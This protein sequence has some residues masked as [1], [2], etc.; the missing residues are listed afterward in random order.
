MKEKRNFLI[1]LR[2]SSKERQ[3]LDEIVEDMGESQSMCVRQLIREYWRY[4]NS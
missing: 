1:A 3:M 2:L 4:I